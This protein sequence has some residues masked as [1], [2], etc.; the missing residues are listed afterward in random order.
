MKTILQTGLLISIA[1]CLSAH[2]YATAPAGNAGAK[3]DESGPFQS[4]VINYHDGDVLEKDTVWDGPVVVDGVLFVPEAVTLTIKPGSII[5]FTKSDAVY[6]ESGIPEAVIPGS[7]LRV[8]GT[9]VAEGTSRTPITFT[10]S[11]ARPAP[12]DWGCIFF[13][14][15]KGS[16]LRYCRFE[17]STYTIHAHFSSLDVIRTVIT[18]NMDGSR[19]GYSRVT[20][21]HCDITDNTGKGLNFSN[22]RNT[23]RYCKITGNNEGIFLNQKDA[24]C[25]IHENNIYGNTRFDLSLG[26]FHVEDMP[27]GVNWWGSADMKSIAAKVYDRADDAEIGQALI[28]PAK[29][30][31]PNAGLE[32]IDIKA[33]WKFKTGG[34]VDSTPAVDG[35]RVYFGS[36]DHNLYCVDVKTGGQIWKF[37]TG[38]CVDSSPA[39]YGGKVYFGSWDRNIYCLD[40]ESGEEIWRYKMEP[41]NFDDHRQSSPAVV[42]DVVYMGG[43][44]GC[45]Y[46]LDAGT[47]DLLWKYR[48]GGPVRSRPLVLG[49]LLSMAQDG[50]AFPEV[51]VGSCDGSLYAILNPDKGAI[52]SFGAGD[53]VT[54]SPLLVG[55][56]LAFGGGDGLLHTVDRINGRELWSFRTG[57]RIEYSSPLLI[58]NMVLTGSTDGMVYAL[59]VNSGDPVWSFDTGGV[60][61]SSPRST[62]HAVVIANNDGAVYWLDVGTGAPVAVFHANDAVQGLSA[63]TDGVV[64]AGSR[65]GYL[66]RLSISK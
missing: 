59:D 62:M 60:I 12:G 26:E 39:I 13:D 61:Y 65:D 7:G 3:Q 28:R 20:I 6:R 16:T 34:F 40:A 63:L 46:A 1:V 57:G 8:E 17:Y 47:G 33:D 38:D 29:R 49:G 9:V 4:R 53:R 14:H 18:R 37:E 45:V 66:Y 21:D 2:A 24:D 54:S 41:S 48:T 44:D 42:K 56:N 32:G 22:C 52:W 58:N 15:S 35:G 31:I 5:N 25:E 30:E 50:K 10:S 55:R 64:Y 43:F 19:L 11:E 27:T 36:W 51:V 23:V